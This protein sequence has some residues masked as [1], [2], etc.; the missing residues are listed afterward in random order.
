MLDNVDA[1]M[2]MALDA[3]RGE[4]P[5]AQLGGNFTDKVWALGNTR[6][7]RVDPVAHENTPAKKTPELKLGAPTGLKGGI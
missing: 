6:M 4:Q 2:Q 1:K 7:Y 5:A 3:V